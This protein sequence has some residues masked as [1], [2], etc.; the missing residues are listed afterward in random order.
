MTFMNFEKETLCKQ[1]KEGNLFNLIKGIYE[2]HA[3]NIILNGERLNTF[4]L[5]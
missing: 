3:A 4:P 1:E 2:K 5:E